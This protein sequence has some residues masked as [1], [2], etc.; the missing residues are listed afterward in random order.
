M[1]ITRVFRLDIQSFRLAVCGLKVNSEHEDDCCVMIELIDSNAQN[2]KQDIV[3]NFVKEAKCCVSKGARP[4][5]VL[6]DQVPLVANKGTVDITKLR[7]S[8]IK[9]FNSISGENSKLNSKGHN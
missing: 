6:F 2:A 7:S 3:D 8:W 1:F 9:H 4:D 5:Y